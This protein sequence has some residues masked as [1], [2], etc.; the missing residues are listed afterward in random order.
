[1]PVVPTGRRSPVGPWD[2]VLLFI[3]LFIFVF[4]LKKSLC[5]C[6]HVKGK[7]KVK[8]EGVLNEKRCLCVEVTH[9]RGT[10]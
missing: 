3:Y 4:D 8:G 6:P 9:F 1:M 10:L 7:L 2:G 5:D